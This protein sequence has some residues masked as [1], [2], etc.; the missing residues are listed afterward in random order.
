MGHIHRPEHMLLSVSD[1][2]YRS[3]AS[4]ESDSRW[5]KLP[6][7]FLVTYTQSGTQKE[8]QLLQRGER[9]REQERAREIDR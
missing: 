7:G 9:D 8:G 6:E 1:T 4:Q 2:K 5:W 3:L